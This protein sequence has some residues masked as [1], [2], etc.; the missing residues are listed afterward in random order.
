MTSLIMQLERDVRYH[1][2]LQYFR[3]TDT[4]D[5]NLLKKSEGTIVTGSNIIKK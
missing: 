5:I 4:T 2:M 1:Q 3:H